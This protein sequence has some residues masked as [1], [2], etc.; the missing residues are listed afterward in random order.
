MDFNKAFTDYSTIEGGKCQTLR[1]RPTQKDA[2]VAAVKAAG[3]NQIAEV[4]KEWFFDAAQYEMFC[5]RLDILKN[6]GGVGDE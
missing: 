3:L 6:A 5:K 4:Q 1:S 2:A